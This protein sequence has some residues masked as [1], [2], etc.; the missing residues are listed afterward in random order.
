[1]ST[2]KYITK[3]LDTISHM[4]YNEIELAPPNKKEETK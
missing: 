2:I 4:I 1:V 3:A